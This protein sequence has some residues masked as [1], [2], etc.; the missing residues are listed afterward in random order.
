[1]QKVWFDKDALEKIVVNLLSN[2]IKYNPK[3]GSVELKLLRNNEQLTIEVKNTGKGL[4]QEQ[5]IKIFERFYQVDEHQEGTGIG[6]ALVNELVTLHKGGITASSETNGWTS[7]TVTLPI[8]KRFFK[9][10]EIFSSVKSSDVQ[11]AL[12]AANI[13]DLD[14]EDI[15]NNEMPVLLVVDDNK[16]VRSLLK[17]TFKSTYSV[18][19]AKN[20]EEGIQKALEHIPDLIVSDIMMPGTDGLELCGKLKSDVL[21]SHIPIILLTA[22]AGEEDQYKGLS[23]G[24][25]AYVTKPFRVKLLRTRVDSLIESRKVLRKRYGQEVIL[26]PKDIAITNL[27]EQFLEKIQNVLDE[28]LTGSNFSAQE[29]SVAMGMSR[30]QLHRKLKALTG[31][32]TSEFVRSQRLRLAASLLEK[33]D[34]NVSQIGYRVGFNDP[35]YF[36]R[37]F[38]EAYGCSPTEF[39]SE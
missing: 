10:S 16:D 32:T 31:L 28:K 37:C 3:K 19:S 30:M 1:V 17:S 11:D 26:K 34:A 24:A 7:F 22:R 8:D 20:G 29:F 5:L 18:V 14:A 35:S 27:D 21:T 38:K 13:P 12:P 9:D 39:T 6:L 15:L 36:T 2:A 33:S 25:D 23:L 4:S